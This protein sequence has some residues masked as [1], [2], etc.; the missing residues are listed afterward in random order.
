MCS[1]FCVSFCSLLCFFLSSCCPVVLFDHRVS[2]LLWFCIYVMCLLYFC[3]YM[4]S[5]FS[6]YRSFLFYVFFLVF[7]LRVYLLFR[8]MFY[9]FSCCVF[10]A[11]FL[12]SVYAYLFFSCLFVLIVS[13]YLCF[14]SSLFSIVLFIFLLSFLFCVIIIIPYFLFRVSIM[15]VCLVF[16]FLFYPLF[17]FS[18]LLALGE[19]TAIFCWLLTAKTLA[20]V[21]CTLVKFCTLSSPVLVDFCLIWAL[22]LYFCLLFGSFWRSFGSLDHFL[23][24]WGGLGAAGAQRSEKGTSST[25]PSGGSLLV[26]FCKMFS[27]VRFY[28]V[29]W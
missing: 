10:V 21:L 3:L 24:A 7:F 23:R 4:C 19:T 1:V 28:V 5:L 13:C 20:L 9:F 22:F 12:F 18:V 6:C 8:S 27:K 15:F 2:F 17:L 11:S 26:T 29:F 25:P 14:S 16:S